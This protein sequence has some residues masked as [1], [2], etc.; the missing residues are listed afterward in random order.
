MIKPNDRV[1]LVW[2]CCPEIRRYIGWVATI[3]AISPRRSCCKFCGKITD[4]PLAEFSEA[5]GQGYIPIAW[6]RK[7]PPDDE[8]LDE[9]IVQRVTEKA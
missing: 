9:K 7:L 4:G 5:R 3:A 2:G 1:M 6:L 8:P